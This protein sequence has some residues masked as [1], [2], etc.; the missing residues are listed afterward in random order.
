LEQKLLVKLPELLQVVDNVLSSQD[1]ERGS[2]T[3]YV[4]YSGSS[5]LDNTTQ[6]FSD[7]ESLTCNQ[8][9]SSGLLGNST[10]AAGTPFANTLS[11]DAT[12]TGSVFQIEE[13]VYFIRGYF[14]NVNKESLILDQYTNKPSYRVGLFVS[15]EIINANA[16]ESLNDN[17][18]GFNNY[19]APGADR[20]Q[21]SVSLFKKSIDD[22]N[23]DNFV[24]LATIENGNLKT[25]LTRRGGASRGNG[26][27]FHEDLND[28]LARRT[29][30][31][32][33]HYI[34]KPFNVSIVNSLNNNLG[35]QGLYEP[36]QFTA[37]GTAANAD[38]A[39]CRISPGKAYVKGY[40]IETIGNTI[41][42]LPKPRTTRTVENQFLRYNTGPTLKL[43][44]VHRSP[45]VGVGNTFILSLRDER[46]G[47]NSE[48]APG[49]EIGFARVFDFRLESGSYNS[50]LPDDNEWGMS[51]YDIQ[52]FTEIE[53]NESLSLTIPSY[54]EGSNSGATAFLRSPVVGTALTVYDK[55][56]EFIKNETLVFRSGISTQSTT[57]NRIA[58]TITP[59]GISNVKSVYSNTGI[60][61]DPDNHEN[62]AGIN[63]FSANVVQTPSATIGVASVTKVDSMGI[64]T[65]TSSNKL[66]PGNIK[67]NSLL[68]YSDISISD[69]PITA[70]VVSVGSSHITVTGVTTVTGVVSGNLPASDFVASD[71]ELL[72]TQLDSSS[73]STLFTELPKENISTINLT[74][75][76]ITIRKTFTVTITDEQLNST[77][78][79]TVT[80]PEGETY[81]PYSDERYTLIRSDGVT[82]SLS[83]D[84]FQ[85]STNLREVQIRN[86]G[87]NN[88]GAKLIVTGQKIEY[89]S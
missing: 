76:E 72:T 46:I 44:S 63:T 43:N 62:I 53:V 17:S 9:I 73:D 33:G 78:L 86:L 29:F 49:K 13:G 23:D 24:E 81:L 5:R 69:D 74:D 27:V 36:G 8:I 67:V 70:K 37:G 66:F 75:A 4:S 52:P 19:G 61:A 2:V 3:L 82:E 47:G 12:A 31:E 80:L 35:N 7:G 71:L 55:K 14:V 68:Q 32:S 56:G 57:I 89:K 10:I 88:V 26:A 45:T 22:F 50:A 30:D 20:L 11:N 87:T 21:I 39:L 40:E 59:Y 28:V 38:L 34:V 42:D 16:D 25:S 65:V 51:M 58:K 83:A 84:K 1:S 54:V 18:Q 79:G 15:E 64:S 41:I 85:F 6:T 48:T 60:A 77:S